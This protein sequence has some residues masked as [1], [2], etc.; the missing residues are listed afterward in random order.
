[1]ARYPVGQPVRLSATVKDVTGALVNAGALTLTVQKPDASTQAYASP[2][3]D[4]TGTYHQ[5]VPTADLTSVGHY[6]YKWVSTG[7]GAGV[8]YGSFDSA[9]G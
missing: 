9:A 3:N 4:S 7:T 5:D 2:T 1:M 6:Q 8:S